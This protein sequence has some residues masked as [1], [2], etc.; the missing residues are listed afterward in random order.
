MEKFMVKIGNMF[1]KNKQKFRIAKHPKS[2]GQKIGF[3]NFLTSWQKTL[4][5]LKNKDWKRYR[6]YKKA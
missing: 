3:F 6:K 1:N 4:D 5:A 2:H